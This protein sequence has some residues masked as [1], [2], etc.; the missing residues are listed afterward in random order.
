MTR[1]TLL[2]ILSLVVV[3]AIV[4]RL[5]WY[6]NGYSN[7]LH[8]S[9]YYDYGYY[10]IYPETILGSLNRGVTEVFTPASEEIWDRGEQYDEAFHWSQ[11]DYLTIANAFSQEVWHESWDPKEWKVLYLSL[12]QSCEDNPQGFYDFSIVYFKNLGMGFL[13]RQYQTRL[14]DIIPWQGL[15]R[16]GE[17]SFSDALL[18]GWGNASLNNFKITA[19]DALLIAERN[20]GGKLR[21]EDNNQCRISVWLNNYPPVTG[22]TNNNWLVDYGMGDFSIYINPYSG[23]FRSD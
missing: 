9:Q 8:F 3:I 16:W 11:S 15:I 12:H 17:A 14:I 7:P 2:L 4:S 21:Q 19:D 22:Y 13:D 10:E 5:V 6:D 20:G 23:K 1:K 18:P